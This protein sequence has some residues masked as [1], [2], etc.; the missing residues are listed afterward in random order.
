MSDL[1]SWIK[2]AL[3][4]DYPSP[5]DAVGIHDP[6]HVKPEVLREQEEQVH[7]S[8]A[9]AE[10]ENTLLVGSR[11]AY[12]LPH[13]RMGFDR[14]AVMSDCMDAW[15]FNPLARR[16]VELTSQYVVGGGM[17]PVC[18]HAPTQAFLNHF[19]QHR[20]NHLP[21]RLID[22]SDE[23][24]RSGNLFLLLSTDPG[25]MSYLR[26]VPSADISEI[27]SRD[28]DVE[29]ELEY[30]LKPAVDG[31]EQRYAAYD[32]YTDGLNAHGEFGT[33]M[34]HYVVNRPA[35]AQWGES[36]L[37]PVLR[38]LSRYTS[39]L[40]DRVRLNRFR[41][42]FIYVV[43]AHFANESARQARQTQLL[44]TP[45]SPGS[46]LVTD[47]SEEWS[48]LSPRLEALDASTDGLAIKKMI[49]AGVGVPLHFLAEPESSTRT[50]AE[51]A[52]GP[53]FRRF[54]Q[55]QRFMQWMLSDLCQIVVARRAQ[56]DRAV[57]SPAEIN[58][59]AADISTKD[60]PSLA[61]AGREVTEFA[62]DLLDKE[63]I[64]RE[65]Y[66]RLV[67]RF[68]DEPLPIASGDVNP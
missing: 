52:G 51:A 7:A 6:Y 59:Q 64:S 36:D 3:H 5:L 19:W 41:N 15:R 40:E 56:M 57:I 58:I 53:T 48:V 14:E 21:V 37:G 13:D 4:I 30:R 34:L 8:L 42:A 67:Y 46:V 22:M 65:E 33:V 27:R 25:G 9:L 39:W 44:A 2:E 16:I 32:A 23:L 66:L 47:E 62:A 55:R 38:W 54:E 1:I 20:L 49:A 29:Q 50:T 24:V 31:E 61:Q 26:L 45:P 43:K 63:L 68:I 10:T 17:N 60:N 12:G 28:N 35:G 18:P 11:S